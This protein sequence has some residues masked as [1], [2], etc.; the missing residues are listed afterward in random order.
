[1]KE[2]GLIRE[3]KNLKEK[4]ETSYRKYEY[5]GFEILVGKNNKQNDDLTRSASREDIWLH[6]HEIPVLM[7]IKSAGRAVPEQVIKYAAR[8]AATFSKAKNVSN[9]AVDYTQR[10][11]YGNPKE[12]NPG[13]GYMKTMK[14]YS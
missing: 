7:I 4:S 10:K 14:Q 12:L 8:I 2:Q 1:M 11:T 13:C 9:V 3:T 6:T 5:E